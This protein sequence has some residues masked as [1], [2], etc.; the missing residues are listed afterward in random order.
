VR[1]TVLM[2]LC[3]GCGRVGFDSLGARS[4][5]GGGGG[6]DGGGSDVGMQ[7][8]VSNLMFVTSTTVVPG[9]L[10]GI[11]RADGECNARAVAV[12]LQGTYVAYLTTAGVGGA[13]RLA[14]SR[15]WQRVDGRPIVDTVADLKT[16]DLLYPPVLDESGVRVPDDSVVVTGTNAD[17]TAGD[18]CAEWT[19]QSLSVNL[20]Q[21]G[22]T[23]AN[24]VAGLYSACSTSARLFCFGVGNSA[25]VAPT[26]PAG[27]TAFLAATVVVVANGSRGD[28]DARCQSEAAMNSIAG[29]FLA[30]LPDA[31]T[32]AISRFDTTKATWYRLDGAALAT[33]PDALAAGALLAP[34]NQ[35]ADRSR[36]AQDFYAWTG[37]V[38]PNAVG[39][40]TGTCRSW[41]RN[42]STNGGGIGFP[43]VLGATHFVGSSQMCSAA[44][45][46][47]CLEQ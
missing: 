15:G 4:D 27:R 18:S 32:S 5:D 24:W 35:Y 8:I 36:I 41:S 2:L 6:D 10:G 34:L 38:L 13:D 17:G 40:D 21:V 9:A 22:W 37:N 14:G 44:N 39:S 33:S 47:Y 31:T 46:V 3:A 25:A 7:P 30:L 29:T 26:A 11:A 20:G 12:G 45:A 1:G 16:M 42:T 28:A 43:A 23:D 19:N